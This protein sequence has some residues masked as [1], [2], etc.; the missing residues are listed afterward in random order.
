MEGPSDDIQVQAG[1]A[2]LGTSEKWRR[3]TPIQGQPVGISTSTKEGIRDYPDSLFFLLLCFLLSLLLC[4]IHSSFFFSISLLSVLC[5]FM[6]SNLKMQSAAPPGGTCTC[7][8]TLS[9]TITPP[10][11]LR[12]LRSC[13]HAT[14]HPPDVPLLSAGQ[15]LSLLLSLRPTV[16]L[17]ELMLQDA[18]LKWACS[19][20]PWDWPS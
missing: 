4:L 17:T 10:D 11:V 2:P 7:R 19:P 20:K 15:L 1:D 9:L 13:A 6:P 18:A 3:T 8:P 16:K 12:A 5:V 14:A